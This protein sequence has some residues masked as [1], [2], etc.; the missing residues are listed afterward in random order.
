MSYPFLGI[1]KYPQFET[2]KYAQMKLLLAL[3]TL[4]RSN[5]KLRHN[6]KYVIVWYWINSTP[7]L[8]T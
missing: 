2:Q 3:V 4:Q 7:K 8:I 6:Y 1:K 5:I